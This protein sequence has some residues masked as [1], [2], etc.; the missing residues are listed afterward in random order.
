MAMDVPAPPVAGA[1]NIRDKS[2]I[3]CA[4]PEDLRGIYIADSRS[5]R[6]SLCASKTEKGHELKLLDDAGSPVLSNLTN[7]A[8]QSQVGSREEKLRLDC[9]ICGVSY[10][11]SKPSEPLAKRPAKKAKGTKGYR[12]AQVRVVFTILHR[13]A[14]TVFPLGSPPNHRLYKISRTEK[15]GERMASIVPVESI[16]RSIHLIPKFV[17]RLNGNRAGPC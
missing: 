7:H 1:A 3:M 10:H 6:S 17:R 13:I 2:H 8:S 11:M 14:Q 9:R 5:S 16:R 12:V 15:D 4:C